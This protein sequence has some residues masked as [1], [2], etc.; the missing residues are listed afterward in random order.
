MCFISHEADLRYSY[1]LISLLT[2][3]QETRGC[4]CTV[5]NSDASDQVK[6]LY[7]T[8]CPT[9]PVFSVLPLEGAPLSVGVSS[10]D[11]YV[12]VLVFLC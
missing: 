12:S 4:V 6:L 2:V 7:P 11:H 9:V 10:P 3:A 8:W 1:L 5:I